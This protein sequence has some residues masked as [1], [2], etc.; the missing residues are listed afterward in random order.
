[1]AEEDPIALARVGRRRRNK[2]DSS[3]KKEQVE[4][5]EKV[6]HSDSERVHSA[7]STGSGDSSRSGGSLGSVN[8]PG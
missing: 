2:V 8:G 3:T 5:R 7:L 4:Q 6:E 1:M